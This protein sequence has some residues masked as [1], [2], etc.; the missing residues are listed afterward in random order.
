MIF[1]AL[2]VGFLVW[3]SARIDSGVYLRCLCR[4]RDAGRAVALTF[5]DGPDPVW[6]PRVLDVLAEFGVRATFFVVGSRAERCPELVRRIVAEGHILGNHTRSHSA[7]LPL[8]S[9]RRLGR[10]L[11]HTRQTV[12]R[13]TGLRMALFRPPFGVTNPAVARAVRRGGYRAVGWSIRALDTA[14]ATSRERVVRR[15]VGALHDGAVILLHDR[16]EGADEL[17]RAVLVALQER[18][19][20]LRTIDELFDIEAYE[21]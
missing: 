16:C 19:Y 8:C 13:L 9:A 12:E 2:V 5:D 14:A 4:N 18:G 10:E 15:T 11:E 21:T 3:A 20:V 17:V 7:R 1:G 6:T